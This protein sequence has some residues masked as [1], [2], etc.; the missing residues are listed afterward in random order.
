M[1]TTTP[2]SPAPALSPGKAWLVGGGLALVAATS[3]AAALMLRAPVGTPQ[4]TGAVGT[5]VTKSEPHET[6]VSTLS[7]APKANPPTAAP[8]A[9]PSTTAR[10]TARDAAPP[11]PRSMAEAKRL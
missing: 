1:N 9:A 4:A 10:S 3:L 11:R 5:P 6:I 8:A 7:P 2:I